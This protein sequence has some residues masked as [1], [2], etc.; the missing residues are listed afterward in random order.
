MVEEQSYIFDFSRVDSFFDEFN[1]KFKLSD[2]NVPNNNGEITTNLKN[3]KLILASHCP[4]NINECLNSN[5]T[6]DTSVV[7]IPD[8]STK[9]IGLDWIKR[10]YGEGTIELHD[11]VI[12]NIGAVEQPLKAV[13]LT[14]NTGYVMGYSINPVTINVTNRIVFD[15][16]VIFWDIS[17]LHNGG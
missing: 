10:G 3:F 1:K 4:E 16:D 11:E 8:N 7:T 2:M 13:F 12:F 15:D 14:T 6:L 17:R 5:G 9:I